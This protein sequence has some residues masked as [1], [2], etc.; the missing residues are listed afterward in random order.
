MNGDTAQW[1]RRGAAYRPSR[2]SSSKPALCT[3]RTRPASG[4]SRSTTTRWPPR[5]SSC[6]SGGNRRCVIILHMACA[7]T[8]LP[9]QR[10]C[11]WDGIE[12]DVAEPGEP[13]KVIKLWARRVWTLELSLVRTSLSPF[14][15]LCCSSARSLRLIVLLLV[16]RYDGGSCG[17][18]WFCTRWIP[19]S[20]S[21]ILDV[22]YHDACPD[23]D[24][25]TRIRLHGAAATIQISE[26][27]GAW[28]VI[29]GNNTSRA[30]VH[31]IVHVLRWC[32]AHM[33]VFLSCTFKRR[34]SELYE[35][36][37]FR[38]S[39]GGI[40][41]DDNPLVGHR[42]VSRV[43][44]AIAWEY[45]RMT[46]IAIFNAELTS[47]RTYKSLFSAPFLRVTVRSLDRL[48]RGW[49]YIPHLQSIAT[50]PVSR[51]EP[52]YA[53]H[54]HTL[55]QSHT[56]SCTHI[57]HGTR[58]RPRRARQ[59]GTNVG[60]VPLF[61]SLFKF[62][63]YRYSSIDSD[64]TRCDD[65]AGVCVCVDRRRYSRDATLAGSTSTATRTGTRTGVCTG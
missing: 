29:Q 65:A 61:L 28:N 62:A 43:S 54:P 27:P 60:T 1:S 44:M 25:V 47:V 31:P 36:L 49:T 39:A 19:Y 2:S 57:K 56:C 48:S 23:A 50:K 5:R 34:M 63:S 11:W 37:S 38:T 51:T 6:C 16:D 3:P 15:L 18:S 64:A 32:A 41:P 9:W 59:R 13:S 22:R 52:G 24:S 26:L 12:V 7:R 4:R 30:S 8:S 17:H 35:H 45:I 46:V 14:P 20:Y 55:I 40:P 10:K 33:A 42:D 21:R 58:L 53:Y